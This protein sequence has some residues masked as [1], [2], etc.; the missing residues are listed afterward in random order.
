MT[1]LDLLLG[2]ERPKLDHSWANDDIVGNRVISERAQNVIR[3]VSHTVYNRLDALVA[4]VIPDLHHFIRAKTDQVIPFFVDVQVR[5]RSVMSVKL[6][7]LLKGVG[8]PEDDVTLFAAACHLLMLNWVNET[9]NALLMKVKSPL[10]AIGKG[11][12]VVHMDEAIQRW[13]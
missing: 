12:Q 9:I 1:C 5:D 3:T 10:L 8:L 6:V 13:G 4:F 2:L 11:G 7:K